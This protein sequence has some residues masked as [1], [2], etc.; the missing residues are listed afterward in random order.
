MN[1]KK[2][3]NLYL[4]FSISAI[5]IVF[6]NGCTTVLVSPYDDKLVTDT[7]AFYKKAAGMIELGRSVSPFNDK[8]RADISN[9]ATHAGHFSKFESKYNSLIIDSEALI[10]RGMAGDS[11]ISEAGQAIQS[12][13]NELIEA[14]F[15]SSC[16]KLAGQFAE[17]SL[18]VKNYVDLKCLVLKWKERHSDI[19]HTRQTKILKEGNWEGRKR[20]LFNAVLDIQKAELSKKDKQT[21][22]SE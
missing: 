18:T 11:K 10:L 16:E 5:L 9:I 4:R 21:K 20:I 14:K 7:E 22:G 1:I 3:F 6:L 19:D 15:P 13:I 8:K 12:K 17:R 2:V